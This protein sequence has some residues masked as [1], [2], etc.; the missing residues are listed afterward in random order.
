MARIESIRPGEELNGTLEEYPL[1]ELLI[2]ILRGNLSGYFELALGSHRNYVYFKDGVPV[3]VMLP[4]LEV[5]L[6]QILVA[7]GEIPE[8]IGL[9]VQQ[10]AQS[11][12]HSESQVVSIDRLLADGA[13]H[14]AMRTRARAQLV[15]LFDVPGAK[16]R[17]VEGA[18]MPSDAELTILQPL[19][20]IYEG[21]LSAQDRRPVRQFLAKTVGARFRLGDTY[22][23][24]VD[25]FEWGEEVERVVG[26]LEGPTTAQDMTGMGLHPDQVAVALTTLWL[27]DMLDVLESV[28]LRPASSP[29]LSE[30]PMALPDRRAMARA[31]KTQPPMA[32]PVRSPQASPIPAAVSAPVPAPVP[33]PAAAPAPV[34]APEAPTQP[35][36]AT[37]HY[38]H[39]DHDTEKALVAAKLGPLRNKTY[40]EVLRVTPGSSAEQIERSYRFF[41]RSGDD[42]DPGDRA[43]RAVATEARAM[44]I[45]S[46]DAV[47]YRDL[48][49]KTKGKPKLIR[50]R[51]ALE[52]AAK[53]DRAV[54]AMAEGHTGEADYLLDWAAELD[55]SRRDL[56]IHRAFMSFCKAEEPMRD[57]VAKALRPMIASEALKNR[58]DGRLQL[59]FAAVVA[60]LGEV[61]MASGIYTHTRDKDQ[62]LA[63]LVARI[64]HAHG[65]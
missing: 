51:F 33:A 53:I 55:P 58:E 20:V 10:K 35:P 5:S 19:P 23:R 27:A 48:V 32:S 59:Y 30:G 45:D 29:H 47:R 34:Q 25:P 38:R 31:A 46:P 49:T 50:D 42:A 8:E 9:S 64:L 13:L 36:E 40:F 63:K 6:A 16:F 39:V 62:P 22:P 7:Y 61:D 4:D 43:F 15:K 21:L 24:G 12:G 60:E 18:A 26:Q 17:F 14:T 28:S 44:L 37:A 56:R 11:S 41:S 2:G 1:P 65:G 3:S 52:V 57:A 54:Q